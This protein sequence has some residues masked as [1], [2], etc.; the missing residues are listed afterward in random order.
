MTK[1]LGFSGSNGLFR[2]CR[3]SIYVWGNKIPLNSTFQNLFSLSIV[4]FNR[5]EREG[6][7]A[8]ERYACYNHR[9]IWSLEVERLR[10]FAKTKESLA[11]RQA[12]LIR[13]RKQCEFYTPF[14]G[15]C[16]FKM[17]MC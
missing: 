1:W 14:L 11:F 16:V 4:S 17:S 9:M 6:D 8:E 5:F 12:K 2:P 3:W 10:T 15:C 13:V 7:V